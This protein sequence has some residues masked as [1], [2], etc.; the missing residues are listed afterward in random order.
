MKCIHTLPHVVIEGKKSSVAAKS[1]IFSSHSLVPK[2][3][4]LDLIR[5]GHWFSE[6]K[7]A[8]AKNARAVGSLISL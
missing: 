1:E 2:K 6:N 4:A 7:F 3:L 5:G 8:K